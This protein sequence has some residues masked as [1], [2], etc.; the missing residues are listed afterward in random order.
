MRMRKFW[1]QFHK[2]SG[3][4]VLIPLL[5]QSISGSIIVFDHAIDEWLNS[6]ILCIDTTNKTPAPLSDVIT[7]A[8]NAVPG[9]TSIQVRKPRHDKTVYMAYPVMENHSP[10][11]D[12][13]LEVLID[14]YTAE[15]IAVREW[16]HYFTSFIYLLHFTLLMGHS[17]ELL[18]GFLAILVFVNVVVGVYLGWP[19]NAGAWRWLLASSSQKKPLLSQLRRWHILAGLLSLPVFILLIVSGI[20]LIFDKQTN[21]L[22]NSPTPP[23]LSIRTQS[24]QPT[25]SDDWLAMIKHYWPNAEWM[26]INQSHDAET[27]TVVTLRTANDPRKTSGSSRLWLDPYNHHIIAEQNYNT[28]SLRQKI[29]FWLFPLHSGEAFAITGRLFVFS[30]GLLVTLLTIAGGWLWYRRRR[31]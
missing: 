10:Y 9:T 4:I 22:L 26:R 11:A 20:G 25:A 1:I 13:R 18:L 17:G 3:L 14:P 7:T 27:A 28:L 15:V 16:G 12:Q 29:Y 19:K 24:A 21:A 6:D 30:S 31:R 2:I 8:K 5:L 23:Q